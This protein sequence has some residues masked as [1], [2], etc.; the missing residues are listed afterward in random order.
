MTHDMKLGMEVSKLWRLE[1][2]FPN[3]L[4]W[5]TKNPIKKFHGPQN[6]TTEV[7]RTIN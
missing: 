2:L 7:L 1:Q 4:R 5:R 6:V 3:I